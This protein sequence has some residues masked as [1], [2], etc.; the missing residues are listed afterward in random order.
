MR[1]LAIAAAAAV[2]ASCASNAPPSVLLTLPSAAGA[3]ASAA[4]P[5]EGAG[6]V[7][8][9][10]RVGIPEYLQTRRVRYRAQD[11]VVENWPGVYWAE[12]LEVGVSRELAAALR[13]ALPGWTICEASCTQGEAEWS[14]S[15]ELRPLDF[16]RARREL[17]GHARWTVVRM[18]PSPSVAWT[19]EHREAVPASADTPQAHAR[20]ITELLQGLARTLADRLN[21]TP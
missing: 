2:L 14:L 21:G 11:S 3:P 6:R 10:R 19:G 20:A 5:K 13:E 17:L 4:A 9:V 18:R 8:V 12:R 7:L 15:L 1:R 16:V